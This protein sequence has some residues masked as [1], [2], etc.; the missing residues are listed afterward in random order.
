M[1][2]GITRISDIVVPAI[3]G[4]Y[5]QN[6]TM[7]KVAILRS[8]A[9]VENPLLSS[10]LRGGGLTFNRPGFRDLD[11]DADNVSV[12]DPTVKSSPNKIGTLTEIQVRMNRNQSWSSM[13]L[14]A[15]LAGADPMNAIA[16]LVSSYWAR[17]W[18]AAFLAKMAGIVANNA[19][20]TDAYHTQNDYTFDASGSAFVDGVTNFSAEAFIDATGT[21]GDAAEGNLSLACMHSVVYNRAKKNNLIDFVSDSV[22]GEAI[23]IPTFLG[24]VVV[25]DDGMPN[26][27]GVFETWIFGRGALQY[28]TASPEVPTEVKRDPDAG[29][30]SGQETLYS[31]IQ[32]TMHMNGYA[33]VGT[34]A[35]GGPSNAA[36]AN[37]LAN[38][39]S[40]RRVWPERKQIKFARLLTRES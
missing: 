4:P 6:L 17:R 26:T 13:D 10:D 27:G 36:T 15:Q 5:V 34:P 39:A 18:Q 11:N 24:K 1:S 23:R 29:N 40:W 14:A 37:N 28:G 3:F 21:M 25:V 8:G 33:Y 16:N 30:G 20:A 31:R 12:D 7:Q 35:N 19:T 22:N 32:L 2:S 38:A 9:M